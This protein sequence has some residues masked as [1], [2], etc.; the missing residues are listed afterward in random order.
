MNFMHEDDDLQ[1]SEE[2]LQKIRMDIDEF[3]QEY[4]ELAWEQHQKRPPQNE[5]IKLEITITEEHEL[6]AYRKITKFK[7]IYSLK[8]DVAH[9]FQRQ[10]GGVT[11]EELAKIS[12]LCNLQCLYVHNMPVTGEF[13]KDFVSLKKLHKLEF[14]NCPIGDSFFDYIHI[15]SPLD[16]LTLY[17]CEE[18]GFHSPKLD[19]LLKC[20]NL[21][22]LSLTYSNYSDDFI[23]R[24]PSHP[25]TTSLNLEGNKLTGKKLG[26]LRNMSTLGCL[27]LASNE[28]DD[29]GVKHLTNSIPPNLGDL[30]IGGNQITDAALP[31]IA[32]N[33]S[34]RMLSLK[35]NSNISDKGIQ[36]LSKMQQLRQIFLDNTQVTLEGAKKLQQSLRK[37]YIELGNIEGIG[38]DITLDPLEYPED[39]D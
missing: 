31:I 5:G 6:Y 7:E 33:R 10:R 35:H 39:Y 15:I 12:A 29:E 9:D 3:W 22:Y 37:C 21:K 34:I 32:E 17:I 1:V 11:D 24:L 28:I 4:R 8:L 2:D 16:N 25:T 27:Y 36:A 14:Q 13:L 38:K 23:A 19:N 26:F 20:E 18:D 30:D